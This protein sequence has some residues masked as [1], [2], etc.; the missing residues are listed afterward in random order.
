MKGLSRQP[1]QRLYYHGW[2][3]VAICVVAQFTAMGVLINCFSLFVGGW[4]V[5]FDTP[6]STLALG[7]TV[8]SLTCAIWCP[9]VSLL[10]ERLALRTIMAVALVGV[11][12]LHVAIG[13][14]TTGWQIVALYSVLAGLVITFST[15]VPAQTMVAR[16]FVRR[17]G[18]AMGLTS[19]GVA[20]AGV[21]FPPIVS[22]LL[23]QIGW[24]GTWFLF[25]ALI[26]IVVAPLVFMVLREQPTAAEGV[27][28][29]GS[30]A[31]QGSGPR[32]P[33]STIMLNR[34]FLITI[35]CFTTVQSAM[36]VLTVSVAPIVTSRG[37]DLPAAALIISAYSIAALIAK[38]VAGVCADRF[39]NGSPL[40]LLRCP[41]RPVAAC[42]RLPRA[43]LP[44]V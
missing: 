32:V 4:S 31:E 20:M 40:K 28:Y 9:M 21:L 43:C 39:G 34:N 24:R 8:F 27:D 30:P 35:T 26:G 14:A 15:G 18:L 42:L 25:A 17:R 38:L 6:I 1:E 44:S 19:F 2:N 5:E 10:A 22:W 16:W 7:L 13:L 12:L 36:M 3:I 33:I 23:P 37:F 11:A 41:A 29:V